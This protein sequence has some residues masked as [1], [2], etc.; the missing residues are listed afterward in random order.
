MEIHRVELFTNA[1]SH[2]LSTIEAAKTRFQ[3]LTTSNSTPTVLI[4]QIRLCDV[5]LGEI[6]A[7]QSRLEGR[8]GCRDSVRRR[9]ALARRNRS[10]K[11]L[12]VRQAN[13]ANRSGQRR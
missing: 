4:S 3:S 11:R 2:S 5:L 7:I 6:Q 8:M 10:S 13:P 9:S 1:L 12:I